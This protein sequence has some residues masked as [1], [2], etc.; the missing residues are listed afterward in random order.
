[1]PPRV[2]VVEDEHDLATLLAYNLRA[3][4]L[5]VVTAETAADAYREIARGSLDLIILDLMLP[6]AS[7]LDICRRV[8][9]DPATRD[10][11][12]I[13]ASARSEEVDRVVGLELGADDYVVKP[14]SVREVVLRTRVILRRTDS[15]PSPP[16]EVVEFGVLKIDRA[17]HRVFVQGNEVTLTALE[18][19]LLLTLLDRKNRTQSR[20]TLLLDVWQLNTVIESR[21]VDTHVKRLREK[22]GPAAAYIRTVRG[23][24]YRFASSPDEPNTE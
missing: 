5:E 8:R 19:R 9:A 3:D 1:M 15:V 11:P 21:T 14:Y 4:G 22:L 17:A 20:D 13:I 2:L 23:V 24:G 10:I 6:D 18:L 16:S 7:G 12:I